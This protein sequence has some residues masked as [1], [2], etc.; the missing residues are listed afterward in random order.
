[1]RTATFPV[2]FPLPP[3]GRGNGQ[4]RVRLALKA[5]A[6]C[7]GEERQEICNRPCP[8]AVSFLLGG[9]LSKEGPTHAAQ[10]LLPPVPG[11]ARF[12]PTLH[13]EGEEKWQS[14]TSLLLIAVAISHVVI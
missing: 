10:Q 13:L 6:C 5:L 14:D 8:A 4:G 12:H 1:M 11:L 2:T 3:R 7:A 9:R